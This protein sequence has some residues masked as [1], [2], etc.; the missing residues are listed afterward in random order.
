MWHSSSFFGGRRAGQVPSANKAISKAAY[1]ATC[2]S[3]ASLISRWDIG[4]TSSISNKD[5]HYYSTSYLRVLCLA[6]V[7]PISAD[8]FYAI[9]DPDRY[10][11]SLW[12]VANH[13]AS[14]V[15]VGINE[16][17]SMRAEVRP[18]TY[19]TVEELE[20]GDLTVQLLSAV[21]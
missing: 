4:P 5:K 11:C 19:R 18:Q 12:C 16:I 10:R 7:D 14:R 8:V 2:D 15:E 21:H 13:R 1:D 3:V 9:T 20:L 17:L 6:R